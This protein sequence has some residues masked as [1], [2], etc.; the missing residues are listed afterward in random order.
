M[1]KL[2]WVLIV[3]AFFMCC[4]PG[5]KSPEELEAEA[6]RRL[7]KMTEKVD[8]DV[9]AQ[10]TILRRLAYSW[11]SFRVTYCFKK[12]KLIDLKALCI[13][14]AEDSDREVKL[15]LLAKI[16]EFA[17]TDILVFYRQEGMYNHRTRAL[18]S[19]ATLYTGS[20]LKQLMREGWIT[21]KKYNQLWAWAE[22]EARSSIGN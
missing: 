2:A 19:S 4:G 10:K 8:S 20:V 12:E 5:Y 22:S 14:A 21:S 6:T 7:S 13:L 15:A 16:Y 3:L 11:D 17:Q 18:V 1:K 9:S